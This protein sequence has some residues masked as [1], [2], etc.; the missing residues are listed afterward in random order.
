MDVGEGRRFEKEM[1]VCQP[2]G[3]GGGFKVKDFGGSIN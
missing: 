3:S 2:V 1:R